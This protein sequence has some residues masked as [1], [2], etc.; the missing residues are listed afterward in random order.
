M[1]RLRLPPPDEETV[2]RIVKIARRIWRKQEQEGEE[3][4]G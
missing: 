1:R 4:R 3:G 2:E